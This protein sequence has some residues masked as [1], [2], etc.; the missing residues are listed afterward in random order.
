MSLELKQYLGDGVYAEFDGHHIWLKTE[1]DITH[2]IALEP[3]VLAALN[4]YA[5]FVNNTMEGR[6]RAAEE[7]SNHE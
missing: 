5:K 3:A 1:R 7:A 4:N 6:K 2:E